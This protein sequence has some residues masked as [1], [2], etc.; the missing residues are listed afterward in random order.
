MTYAANVTGACTFELPTF[1]QWYLM[2][3]VRRGL[4]TSLAQLFATIPPR[5][6]FFINAL[7]TFC[8]SRW[9]RPESKIACVLIPLYYN[10]FINDF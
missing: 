10:Y 8:V 3:P 6:A 4:L 7:V 9:Q 2:Y 1:V 5:F